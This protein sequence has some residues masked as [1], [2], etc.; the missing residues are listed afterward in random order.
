MITVLSG[1]TGTPKL[2]RGLRQILQDDEITIVVNTA[3]DLWM[4]GLY[5]SPDIDTVQYLFAG[6]LNMDSW[7]GIRGDS[8]ETFHTMERLGY[9]EPLPLGDRDR[10]TNIVRAEFLRQ[11]MTLTKATEKITKAYGIQATILPMS[12]QE[13]A[14]Y[15]ELDGGIL[16][17]YQEY[18]VNRRGN[19]SITG[20]IRR[21]RDNSQLAATSE[22]I[23]A[24]KESDG[25]IIGP[26]NPVTSIGPILE[27]AGVRETLQEKFTIAV[28]PFIGNRPISGPAAALMQAWGYAPTSYGTWE[29][30]KDVVNMF[31]QDTRDTEIEVPCAH[32]LDTMMTTEKKAESLAWDLLSYFPWK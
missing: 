22:V 2:I 30:Y 1:G 18:W 21:T 15:V 17:H 10:A 5:V 8:F 24:I 32:R 11:G 27:C 13:V 14:T 19:V 26:S 20:V 16:M 31:I 6:L 23:T 12:D 7:W 3:E 29:V 9:T 28:S 25:V 4:S